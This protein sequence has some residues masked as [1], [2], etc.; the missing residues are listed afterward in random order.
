M[1]RESEMRVGTFKAMLQDRVSAN[2]L[3]DCDSPPHSLSHIHARTHART[4]A[5]MH[6]L[7]T[8]ACIHT[9]S[10]VKKII[11]PQKQ[12]DIPVETQLKANIT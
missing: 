5:C 1:E 10:K 3:S 12:F 2:R 9:H 8:H 11:L 6:S 7:H 4:H